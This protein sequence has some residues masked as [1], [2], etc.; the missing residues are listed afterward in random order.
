MT[1]PEPI[2]VCDDCVRREFQQLL[3]GGDKAAIT[4]YLLG[5]MVADR[6]DIAADQLAEKVV[7]EFDLH[8]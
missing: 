1:M 8:N 7:T 3:E 6:L 5:L 4:E 2:T